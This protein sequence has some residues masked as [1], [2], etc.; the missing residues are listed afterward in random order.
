MFHIV[1]VA[2]TWIPAAYRLDEIHEKIES[3]G[4]LLEKAKEVNQ[5]C[6]DVICHIVVGNKGLA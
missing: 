2:L 6:K 5:V 4:T 3:F 1:V